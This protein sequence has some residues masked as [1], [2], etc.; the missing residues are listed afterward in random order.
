MSKQEEV[1]I[2]LLLLNVKDIVLN[3]HEVLNSLGEL[4]EHGH[5]VGCHSFAARV[6]N[7]NFLKL[8]E[9]RNS[10]SQ[11]QD[12]LT[13]LREGVET[14]EE[15]VGADL[16]LIFRALFVLKVCILELGAHIQSLSELCVCFVAL[17]V[18][19]TIKDLLTVDVG[20][21]LADDRVTDLT[22]ENDKTSGSVVVLRV[23]PDEQD[24]VHDRHK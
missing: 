19:D 22:D 14:N 16:P 24:C 15:R 6:A 11:V 17:L 10:A 7:L 8:V 12:V 1:I 13:S 5:D 18:L 23:V 20:T 3:E 21:A 4:I 2:E 9:L